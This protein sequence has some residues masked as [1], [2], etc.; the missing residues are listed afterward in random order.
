MISLSMWRYW[1][2]R[3]SV[4]WSNPIPREEIHPQTATETRPERADSFTYSAFQ[5]VP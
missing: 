4:L 1:A 5:R 2:R 3:P